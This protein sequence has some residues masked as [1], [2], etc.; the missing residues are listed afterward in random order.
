VGV[1]IDYHAGEPCYVC[2]VEL[3]RGDLAY[4]LV[5]EHGL[6]WVAHKAC[7]ERALEPAK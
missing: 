5:D 2:H 3:R 4:Y 6:N 7:A 1:N